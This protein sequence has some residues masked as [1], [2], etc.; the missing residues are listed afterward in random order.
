[1]RVGRNI[2]ISTILALSAAGSIAG[3]VAV[4]ATAAQGPSVHVVAGSSY[5]SPQTYFRG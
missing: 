5:A 2:I 3:S 1:M 4:P